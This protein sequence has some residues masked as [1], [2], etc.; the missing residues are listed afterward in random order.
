MTTL[1]L[2]AQNFARPGDTLSVLPLASWSVT[3]CAW[4]LDD[5]LLPG[6]TGQSL[7]LAS[8]WVNGSVKVELA[9]VDELGAAATL[10]SA[11]VKVNAAPLGQPVISGTLEED[12]LV[13]VVTPSAITDADGM[14]DLPIAYQWLADGVEIQGATET[15]LGLGQEQV[16]KKLSVRASYTDGDGRLE[17]V[18]SAS[19]VAVR[20]INDP[21]TGT[22]QLAGDFTEKKTL[23][24][25]LSNLA[26]EDGLPST[27][28]YLWK[29]DETVIQGASSSELMLSQALV[30]K[31]ISLVVQFTDLQGHL[32][33][34]TSE[35]D[36]RVSN[37]NDPTV[38]ALAVKGDVKQGAVLEAVTQNLS[39]LD[40]IGTFTYQW[41]VDG[42]AIG[43]ATN[44]TF[45]V[46]SQNYV[47]KKVTVSVIHT[48][49]LGF[50][51]PALEST[52]SAVENTNDAPTGTLE[53]IGEPVEDSVLT[54]VQSLSDLD[55]LLTEF[56]YQW[57]SDSELISNATASKLVLQQDQVGHR[58]SVQ[59]SY[60]DALGTLE[61]VTSASSLVV[62]NVNDPP[63][64]SVLVSGKLFSGEIL[65]ASTEALSDEDN[66]ALPL[67][68]FSYQWRANDSN[69]AGATSNT[70]QLK[71]AQ[72]G[73]SISV[74]VSYVDS[75][76]A[77]EEIASA[78][79]LAVASENHKPTGQ[80]TI[81]GVPE[82]KAVLKASQNLE[83]PEG[84]G[85]I[86]WRWLADAQ[87]VAYGTDRLELTQAH[88][89]KA[90][91]VIA[92]Y[93][94]ALGQAESVASAATVKVANV[95]DLCTGSLNILGSATQGETLTADVYLVDEDG[96]ASIGYQWLVDGEPLVDATQKAL[97]LS[98]AQVGHAIG[99]KV[100]ATDTFGVQTV[101]QVN[102]PG[103]VENANDPPS[104]KDVIFS[105]FANKK[106]SGTLTAS[107]ADGD[108]FSFLL[109]LAPTHGQ[110]SLN[111]QT[112]LFEYTPNLN[113]SGTDQFSYQATDGIDVSALA[114]VSLNVTALPYRSLAG[115]V[116]FWGDS[117]VGSGHQLLQNVEVKA[118]AGTLAWNSSLTSRAGTYELPNVEA[119]QVSL[120]ASKSTVSDATLK[121]AIGLND[122]LSALKLYLGKTTAD[123]SGYAKVAAD[124]DANGKIELSD[125]LGILKTYLGK[126]SSVTPQWAFVDASANLNGLT[127]K[128]CAVPAVDLNLVDMTTTVSLIG[129]LR[130]DVNGSWSQQ[131]GYDLYS[132]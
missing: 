62:Q 14:G 34:L 80:V 105:G 114:T 18:A 99:L 113:F 63:K 52:T 81:V 103:V 73:Q 83:D 59:V 67:G 109:S 8:A 47:G 51:E 77:K 6:E 90:I 25:Q 2:S 24:A 56:R 104:V 55:G 119:T 127:A 41:L 102:R 44:A 79:T 1:Q 43:G 32:E 57:F 65:T 9:Y 11:A 54:A 121:S 12:G 46:S 92:S 27:F 101:F 33:Q 69:I 39:D 85:A 129:V 17:S 125:V 126:A 31:K 120:S 5:E 26:D 89:G 60:T 4:Y 93:T 29:A 30:G 40:G 21:A 117:L 15:F 48:D 76:G 84:L 28:T 86:T 70:Y 10:T 82:E 36:G 131:S 124:F 49:A 106:L 37:V 19:T 108:P 112:G 132:G 72:V 128:A 111:E 122:V 22:L 68:P 94:D 58:I 38:G 88:V 16:G 20:N 116:Y 96:I 7:L 95:Q 118:T 91:T 123:N 66:G 45:L 74:L 23:A 107:D 100:T 42:Q 61:K 64:G 115:K 110:V 87:V 71:P 13:T 98:Q 78:P 53:I 97:L 3:S 50:T 130:G 75:L 35:N